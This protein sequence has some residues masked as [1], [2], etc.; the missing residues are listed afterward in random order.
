[1]LS[2]KDVLSIVNICLIQNIGTLS[3]K[4]KKS[5]KKELVVFGYFSENCKSI[6]INLENVK[7]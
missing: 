3:A 2:N 6:F 7:S 5:I 4:T 1:M